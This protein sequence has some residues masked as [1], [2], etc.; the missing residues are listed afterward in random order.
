MHGGMLTSA[1]GPCGRVLTRAI[2]FPR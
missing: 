2:G 1:H